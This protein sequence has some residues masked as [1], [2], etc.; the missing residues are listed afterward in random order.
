MVLGSMVLGK[1]A[2]EEMVPEEMVPGE[3]ASKQGVGFRCEQ[4]QVHCD[5]LVWDEACCRRKSNEWS[6]ELGENEHAWLIGK[7]AAFCSMDYQEISAT[8]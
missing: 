6:H 4:K 5:V 3:M 1:M 2:L 7:W 8:L